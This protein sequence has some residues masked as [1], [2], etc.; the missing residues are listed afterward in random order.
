M[1]HAR[2][3]CHD[4][5]E[6]QFLFVGSWRHTKMS[7]FQFERHIK[8]KNKWGKTVLGLSQCCK[9]ASQTYCNIEQKSTILKS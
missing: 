6:M 8:L 4:S 3:Y 1:L 7:E 9:K 5:A 2:L